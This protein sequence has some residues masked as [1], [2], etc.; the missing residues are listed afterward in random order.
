MLE[1]EAVPACP[2]CGSEDGRNVHES[3]DPALEGGRLR[4][5]ECD[6]CQL[7]RLSPRLTERAMLDLEGASDVYLIDDESVADRVAE[8]S[9]FMVGLERFTWPP[10]RM[11]DIGCNR[12][13]LLRAGQLLGWEVTG[14]EIA[15]V[16]AQSARNETGAR[17]VASLDELQGET[18]DLVTGM[19]VLEH[20]ADPVA[21]A[22]QVASLLS[23]RS[24]VAFQVP[25]FDYL[26]E[27]RERGMEGGLVSVS[28]NMYFTEDTVR[29]VLA[30]AGL[31][32]SWMRN[33]RDDLM[34]TVVAANQPRLI[35]RRPAGGRCS[36]SSA[37]PK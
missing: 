27:F 5:F 9:F 6:G 13:F 10:G 1:V 16:A 7:V 34:L 28:H 20:T 3:P 22:R 30:G 37:P 15:P 31:T 17:V 8:L 12:G 2:V 26:A 29:K 25:S 36:P 14:V 11:L 4:L 24:V 32:V 33:Q 23:E 35:S 19:H 18:F 21:F